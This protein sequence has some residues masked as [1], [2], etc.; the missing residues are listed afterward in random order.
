MFPETKLKLSFV[1]G[2]R[3]NE[4][5]KKEEFNTFVTGVRENEMVKKEEF[6]T[7]VQVSEKLRW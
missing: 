6:N 7:F 3:E 4:M 1:T 5:V 2:V